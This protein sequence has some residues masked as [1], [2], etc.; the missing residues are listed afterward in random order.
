MAQHR[1]KAPYVVLALVVIGA[2]VA[3]V[4]SMRGDS[5]DA[6]GCQDWITGGPNSNTSRLDTTLDVPKSEWPRFADILR[7][8]ARRR[9]WSFREGTGRDD[10]DFHWLWMCDGVATMI[11]AG[12]DR[13]GG[14][15]IGFGVIHYEYGVPGRDGWRPHYRALHE[16][17]EAVWPDRMR[18]VEGE[19]GR[20]IQRP[21]WL[22][23][24]VQ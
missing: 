6:G 24:A 17:L 18:Y 15:K 21:P 11:R 23:D 22:D 3:G 16:E 1:S 4:L 10:P 13:E 5:E 20:D 8:F 2:A 12:T 9:G 14:T 7:D 19:F